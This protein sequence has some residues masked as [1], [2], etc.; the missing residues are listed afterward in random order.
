MFKV[1]EI[2]CTS[3]ATAIDFG[4]EGEIGSPYSGAT[5]EAA[6]AGGSPVYS[7]QLEL[8]GTVTATSFSPSPGD[9]I[10]ATIVQS[11]SSTTVTLD[12]ETSE[13]SQGETGASSGKDSIVYEG[14]FLPSSVEKIP[15]FKFL[16]IYG[17]TING[18]ATGKIAQNVIN[19]GPDPTHLQVKT[20][21]LNKTERGWTEKY[22]GAY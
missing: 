10:D 7:G 17:A 14:V 4:I 2:S 13:E 5:V 12:D 21:D 6:C 8:S 18:K 9:V 15:D 1:P 19:M 20:I 3:M 16:Y 11:Q 22:E